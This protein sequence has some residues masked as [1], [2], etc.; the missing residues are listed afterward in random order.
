MSLDHLWRVL[1]RHRSF[2]VSAETVAEKDS[3]LAAL[4][5]AID[6]NNEKRKTFVPDSKIADPL[7]KVHLHFVCILS[8]STRE[9]CVCIV[10][11]R[12]AKLYAKTPPFYGSLFKQNIYCVRYMFQQ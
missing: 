3:W 8:F 5:L 9:L 7:V 10:L 1:C 11:R 12:E 2:T 6:D 4:K